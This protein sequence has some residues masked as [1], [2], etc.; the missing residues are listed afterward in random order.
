MARG[1]CWALCA[2]TVVRAVPILSSRN[3]LSEEILDAGEDSSNEDRQA[4]R[5]TG[6][7]Y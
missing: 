6:P 1:E 3:S 5:G 2:R 4:D 7:K